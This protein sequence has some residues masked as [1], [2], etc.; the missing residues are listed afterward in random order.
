MP[1]RKSRRKSATELPKRAS[2]KRAQKPAQA[3]T[4]AT[5]ARPAR[6]T[7]RQTKKLAATRRRVRAAAEPA[8]A[9]PRRVVK[10]VR[11]IDVPPF[12]PDNKIAP[13]TRT[14]TAR[15]P[16]PKAE[17]AREHMKKMT[18]VE[19]QRVEERHEMTRHRKN[20]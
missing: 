14:V 11:S 10:P 8:P 16:D 4:R 19:A 17:R 3:M 9:A 15:R 13:E 6:V 1:G 12:M 18:G 2:G 7:V 5:A 20:Q